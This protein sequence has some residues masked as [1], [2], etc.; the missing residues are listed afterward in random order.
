MM[1]H[2]ARALPAL[3]VALNDLAEAEALDLGAT[4][5]AWDGDAL[6]EGATARSMQSCAAQ[7]IGA[8]ALSADGLA[9][10]NGL[11][12]AWSRACGTR[13]VPVRDLSQ[14]APD[15]R[16]EA[17]SRAVAQLMAPA[18]N[19]LARQNADL[20]ADLA[21]L[22]VAHEDLEI[23]LRKRTQFVLSQSGGKRWLE[24]AHGPL[25]LSAE[26]AL[27]LPP[28]GRISQRL[29]TGSDG[30]SDI[31]IYLP[32]QPL[33]DEGTLHLRVRLNESGDLAGEW[34]VPARALQ[35]GWL[36]AAWVTALADDLQT[37]EL[38]LAWEAAQP[39]RVGAGVQHPD[40]VLCARLSDGGETPAPDRILAHRV[41]KYMPGCTAPLPIGAHVASA[42][43]E[44]SEYYIDPTHLERALEAEP[45]TPCLQFQPAFGSLQVHPRPGA[46]TAARLPSA[47][48][49]GIVQL[50]ARV[51]ARAPICPPM[52]YALAVVPRHPLRPLADLVEEAL[53]A[54]HASDWMRR[55]RDAEGELAL[56]LPAPLDKTSDLLLVTRVPPGQGASYGWATFRDIRMSS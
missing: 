7:V 24:Q 34:R 52:D 51:G 8:M 4:V 50:S 5:L 30:L 31:A 20:L 9:G 19:D 32:E 36:R 47:V 54:G 13:L 6:L 41:W 55:E 29:K 28:H 2:A 27:L 49:P 45:E 40:R 16:P 37:V 18:F 15:A 23:A 26:G 53:R 44:A 3:I 48:P 11:E 22:R 17:A 25:E 43:P 46:L 10:L 21:R 14:V 33:P 12:D 56:F 39:L 38:D 1:P 35:P 42:A